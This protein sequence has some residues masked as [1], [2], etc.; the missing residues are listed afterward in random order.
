MIF[1]PSGPLALQN[2]SRDPP[3]T[4]SLYDCTRWLIAEAGRTRPRL[5]GVRGGKCDAVH[6]LSL[7]QARWVLRRLR[8]PHQRRPVRTPELLGEDAEELLT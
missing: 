1:W 5:P 6:D 4:A 3:L 8:W 2:I 7:S